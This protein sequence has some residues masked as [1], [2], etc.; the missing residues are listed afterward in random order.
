M[1]EIVVGPKWAALLV[2]VSFRYSMSSCSSPM[3]LKN[4]AKL[5]SGGA[6]SG[7]TLGREGGKSWRK[8]SKRASGH[9]RDDFASK[10]NPKG[11]GEDSKFSSWGTGGC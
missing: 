10:S 8:I 4:E 7:L 6:R 2:A 1:A 5:G 3:E 9:S 11:R